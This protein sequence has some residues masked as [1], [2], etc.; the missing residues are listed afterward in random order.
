MGVPALRAGKFT[1]AA[2]RP[3]GSPRWR[4][5]RAR[6][7]P[8]A[9]QDW[10]G[11]TGRA[12]LADISKRQSVPCHSSKDQ[13]EAS[14]PEEK[15]AKKTFPRFPAQAPAMDCAR[16]DKG[17]LVLSFKKERLPLPLYR[18]GL[19]GRFIIPSQ[20]R[21]PSAARATHRPIGEPLRISA[22]VLWPAGLSCARS[23]R[24]CAK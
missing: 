3:L 15:E 20:T 13:K 22:R 23:C 2:P 7:G 19:G 17:S 1:R 18:M 5:A 8:P 12:G 10:P 11:R 6:R 24:S 9:G 21:A 16:K 14:F 4:S